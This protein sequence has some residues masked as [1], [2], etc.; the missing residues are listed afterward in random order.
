MD[1]ET[2]QPI[3][4]QYETARV[5][6]WLILARNTT[7]L[8]YYATTFGEEV[9]KVWPQPNP[10]LGKVLFLTTRY[11]AIVAVAVTV[12]QDVPNY[13]NVGV[14]GC[15]VLSRVYD[16]VRPIAGTCSEAV[17][18]VFLYALLEGGRKPFYLL[19]GT[20]LSLTIPSQILTW[21]NSARML[22]TSMV[23]VLTWFLIL[24]R[25]STGSSQAVSRVCV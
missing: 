12:P 10:K 7:L 8:Y 19:M 11:S 21:I 18:W 15:V 22:S 2:F 24:H 25:H 13:A 14:K 23:S 1:T 20:F 9:E 16:V 5:W 6:T 4:A 17:L 3:I